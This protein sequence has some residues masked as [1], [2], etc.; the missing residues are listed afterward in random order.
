MRIFLEL[1]VALIVLAASI[2]LPDAAMTIC[3]DTW[4][5]EVG[6]GI[7]CDDAKVVH[8]ASGHDDCH[9]GHAHGHDGRD[10]SPCSDEAAETSCACTDV[11]LHTTDLKASSAG[12]V[13]KLATRQAAISSHLPPVMV[14]APTAGR[15]ARPPARAPPGLVFAHIRTVQ[16]IC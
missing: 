7:H 1:L 6:S 16:L 2:P 15:S 4:Q 3:M 12:T 11:H 9:H 5:V 13:V 14:A 10:H 8:V